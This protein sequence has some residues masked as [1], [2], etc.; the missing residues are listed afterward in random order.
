MYMKRADEVEE[1]NHNL[2]KEMECLKIQNEEL[3]IKVNL[4][5]S[6]SES[7]EI[8]ILDLDEEKLDQNEKI[9]EL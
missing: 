5:S 9:M 1:I 3:K 6:G 7:N 4:H 8:D 2:V